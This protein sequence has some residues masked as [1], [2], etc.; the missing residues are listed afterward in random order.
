MTTAR[1]L[2]GLHGIDAALPGQD[3]KVPR[4]AVLEFQGNGATWALSDDPETGRTIVHI[5]PTASAEVFAS[6]SITAGQNNWNP[7][8][9]SACT[10]LRVD[11]SSGW[12]ITGLDASATI[13]RK[14][15]VNVGSS[16]FYLANESGSSL[17]ANRIVN[18]SSGIYEVRGGQGVVVLYDPTTQRWRILEQAFQLP[19]PSLGRVPISINGTAWV[20][21]GP[22]SVA[23]NPSADTDVTLQLSSAWL[24]VVPWQ[25]TLTANRNLTLSASGAVAGDWATI[26]FAQSANGGFHYNVVNGGAGA[27][28]IYSAPNDGQREVQFTFD[29]TNWS[30]LRQRRWSW[31]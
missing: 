2:D 20:V 13:K 14:T 24:W 23:L 25:D 16:S 29:G 15:I 5:T 30:K 8:G 7:T 6:A 27:G 19:S 22:P 9:F 12:T 31:T 1:L 26:I 10:T 17:A 28:T 4:R 21:G 3:P 18:P 11:A